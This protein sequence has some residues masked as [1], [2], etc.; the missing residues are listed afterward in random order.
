MA[1]I[2]IFPHRFDKFPPKSGF[3]TKGYHYGRKEYILQSKMFGKYCCA[4]L[5]TVFKDD[6]I[7]VCDTF[8]FLSLGQCFQLSSSNESGCTFFDIDNF[9]IVPQCIFS[10][11]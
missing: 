10:Q 8:P 2:S 1:D 7:F 11:Y 5:C 4:T 3:V 6:F 9:L